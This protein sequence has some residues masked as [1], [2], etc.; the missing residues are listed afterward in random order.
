MPRPRKDGKPAARAIRIGIERTSGAGKKWRVR[1]YDPTDGAPHGRVVFI[2]PTTGRP[3]SA[4]PEVGQTLDELFDQVERALTQ[5][6]AMGTTVDGDGKPDPGRR[7]IRALSE[8]YLDHLGLH[9][10]DDDYI[11]NRKSMLKKWILPMI[12]SVL[13]ADWCSEHSQSVIKKARAG[14]LS[15]SRVADIG[16]TLSG[17]R[18]TAWRRR[19]GGR[20]LSQDENPMEEVEYSRDATRQGASRDYI[21][22]QRRPATS[23]VEKAIQTA[24]EV[25]RWGWLTFIISIAAFCALRLSEQLGLRAVD[26]DLRDR[27]LDV[28]GAWS[29]SPS[30]QRA[31]QGK[32]RVGRRKHHPKNKLRRTAP[33]RGSQHDM[34]RRLCALALGLPEGTETEAVA[35]AIDAERERRAVLVRSGDWRDG[36]VPVSDECWLFPS[37]DGLPPT[38]EQFN[39]AWHVVRDACGWSKAIPYKNLRHHA[40]LWWRKQGFAWE[41]IADWDGHAVKTLLSY[42]LVASEDATKEARPKLDLL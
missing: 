4:V 21:P 10:R 3:T 16:S 14:G 20:W 24:A 18:M 23:S 28:N 31:G 25:G 17:M 30:G 11:A 27:L 38:N 2:M 40:A 15:P 13:V 36:K 12:G 39:D 19:P 42:Y 8:M 34:L 35:D 41:T 22:P 9:D 1:S 33:Y 6:V 5:K 29:V 32:V 26:V 7:D 37:E